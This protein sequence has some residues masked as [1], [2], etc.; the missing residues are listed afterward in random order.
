MTPSTTLQLAGA[1]NCRQSL[2]FLSPF[3]LSWYFIASLLAFCCASARWAGS[4]AVSPAPAK[5]ATRRNAERR[6]NLQASS[7]GSLLLL[8]T[9]VTIHAGPEFRIA[10]P[11][12]A[13]WRFVGDPCASWREVGGA[14]GGAK[15]ASAAPGPGRGTHGVD[16]SAA[17]AAHR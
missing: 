14:A 7:M 11:H 3:G 4:T 15:R 2:H 8:G 16:Q 5:N 9:N 17:R 13:R 1:M 10:P 6:V 12:I